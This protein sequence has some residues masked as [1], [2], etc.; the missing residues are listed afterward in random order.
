MAR[1]Q[2]AAA[3][4]GLESALEVARRLVRV[5]ESQARG[6]IASAGDVQVARLR[7][8]LAALRKRYPEGMKALMAELGARDARALVT[9]LEHRLAEATGDL[10]PTDRFE[11]EITVKTPGGFGGS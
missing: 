5:C 2:H 7:R 11:D 6:E 9:H 8:R 1:P 10:T 3:I 4:P